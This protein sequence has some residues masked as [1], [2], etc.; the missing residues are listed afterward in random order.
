MD[1]AAIIPM[2]TSAWP[3]GELNT[4]TEET[5]LY[6][7]NRAIVLGSAAGD[8]RFWIYFT[9]WES[10]YRDSSGVPFCFVE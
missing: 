9:E 2:W 7:K 8:I 3:C 5:Q 1:Q 10:G 6:W 4:A